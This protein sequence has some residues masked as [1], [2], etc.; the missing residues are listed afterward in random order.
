[1][2][3]S[4]IDPIPLLKKSGCP[5]NVIEHCIAVRDL[6]MV[7]ARNA[8]VDKELVEKGALLHDIGRCRTHSIAHGQVGAEICRDYGL[9]EEICRIVET[10]IGAGLTA[11]ECRR[12]G[13]KPVDCVPKT[14]E[15]KIVAHADNLIKGTKEITI[16]ERLDHSANL[17]EAARK[18][19]KD[20]SDEIEKYR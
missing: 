3:I 9:P 13:L 1:M 18:R 8:P 19:M 10:H 20:L 14:L 7:F 12:E 17:P 15:E 4:D 2:K 5:D 11:E 16:D 6:A